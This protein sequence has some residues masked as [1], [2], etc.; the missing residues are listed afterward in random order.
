[1]AA[2]TFYLIRPME[3]FLLLV[4]LIVGRSRFSESER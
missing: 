3:S 1:L 2:E 4:G